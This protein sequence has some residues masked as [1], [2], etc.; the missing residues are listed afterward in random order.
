MIALGITLAI[1]AAAGFAVAAVTQHAAV[2]EHGT[3]LGA[4]CSDRRWLLGI[5]CLLAASGAHA[6]ALALAPLAIVQPLG[7]LALVGST[8]FA[9][10]TDRRGVRLTELLGVGLIV[11]GLAGFVVLAA[12]AIG[13][14]PAEVLDGAIAAGIVL[15]VAA[16]CVLAGLLSG[17]L[18]RCLGFA[19]AGACCY[20]LVSVLT[21]IAGLAIR[22]GAVSLASCC[23]LAGAVLAALA[24]GWLIQHAYAAG[25]GDLVLAV[26]TIGD[27]AVAIA[28]GF[29][30]LGEAYG[31]SSGVLFGLAGAA[32]L[33]VFGIAV[34]TRDRAMHSSTTQVQPKAGSQHVSQRNPAHQRNAGPHRRGHLRPQRERGGALRRTAHRGTGRARARD[35]RGVPE[36]Q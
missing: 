12:P 30:V 18:G 7:V 16:A 13:G 6:V 21:R 5:G 17:G 4:L 29:G 25:P 24:G 9:V 1:L 26:Q 2:A 36:Y 33:A 19:A 14:T 15:A 22:T 23:V 10:R 11:L 20:A 27:P 31:L 35:T 8:A 32:V 28:L 3:R 34:L